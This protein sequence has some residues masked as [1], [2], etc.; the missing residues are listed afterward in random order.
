M[1]AQSWA[2]T[3]HGV[4]DFDHFA[5]QLLSTGL[6]EE[7]LQAILHTE[8]CG[9]FALYSLGT[10]LSAG[11]GLPPFFF[12]EDEA[13]ERVQAW[14]DRPRWRS[15]LNPMWWLGLWVARSM[16]REDWQAIR[17]RLTG[18]RAG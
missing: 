1:F 2:D 16:V 8:V 14:L 7:A 10:L 4:A 12:P 13:R 17:Q 9:A 5:E 18:P 6:D 15:R 3:E 11:M